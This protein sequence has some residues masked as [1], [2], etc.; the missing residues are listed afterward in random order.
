M[1]QSEVLEMYLKVEAL[2]DWNSRRANFLSL[3]T[4]SMQDFSVAGRQ[5]KYLGVKRL[6]LCLFVTS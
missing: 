4:A 3:Q 5:G 2:N 6:H 1:D